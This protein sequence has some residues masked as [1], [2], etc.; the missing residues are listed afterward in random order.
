MELDF[1]KASKIIT[2]LYRIEANLKMIE[3]RCD[4]SVKEYIKDSFEMIE[5]I[6][7]NIFIK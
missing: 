6:N 1:A 4:D 3:R 7:E 5:D 2:M